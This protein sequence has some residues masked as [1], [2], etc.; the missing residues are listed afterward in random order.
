MSTLFVSIA[1][2]FKP[3]SFTN[4][5][6][7]LSSTI[8]KRFFSHSHLLHVCSPFFDKVL[9]FF[10]P[11]LGLLDGHPVFYT[12]HTVYVVR[13]IWWPSPFRLRHWPCGIMWPHHA[14]SR[15]WY[16]GHRPSGDGNVIRV[17]HPILDQI[18]STCRVENGVIHP[19]VGLLEKV[20]RPPDHPE[21]LRLQVGQKVLLGIPFFKQNESIFIL[22]TLAEFVTLASL[23]HPYGIGQWSN[24]L[25]QL[26]AFLRK[27]IHSCD[28]E[29]HN[30]RSNSK[31]PANSWGEGI[32]F[33][34]S[35]NNRWLD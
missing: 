2:I 5:V 9:L 17:F 26:L 20:H 22:C 27:D 1:C 4:F 24:R 21:M 7:F 25:R 28:Y 19:F 3:S 33:D 32:N 23:L 18:S 16:S 8:P 15:P 11:R 12:F 31:W 10:G 14:L 13:L 6:V 34:S 30:R 35:F 29:D